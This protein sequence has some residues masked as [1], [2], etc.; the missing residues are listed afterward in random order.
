MLQI[1]IFHCQ[2]EA[3]C[4]GIGCGVEEVGVV[5]NVREMRV[6]LRGSFRWMV[7]VV[8]VYV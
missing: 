8:V 1:C 4:L 5:G 3:F 2:L 7:V 6:K